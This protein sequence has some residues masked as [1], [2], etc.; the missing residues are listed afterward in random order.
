MRE[1]GGCNGT[2]TMGL[3]IIGGEI[4]LVGAHNLI[5]AGVGVTRFRVTSAGTI[6]NTSGITLGLTLAPVK[7]TSP[8]SGWNNRLR[9]QHRIIGYILP[10]PLKSSSSA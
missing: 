4:S 3:K 10:E 7:T 8:W 5:D 2:A 6:Q 1:T 9:G